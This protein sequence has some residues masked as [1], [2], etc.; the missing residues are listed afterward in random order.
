M[1]EEDAI[2]TIRDVH[3]QVTLQEAIA[4][5]QKADG[6]VN[7]AC[8]FIFAA[9]PAPP[10]EVIT[11]SSDDETDEPAP[12]WWK[13]LNVQRWPMPALTDLPVALQHDFLPPQLAQDLFHFLLEQSKRWRRTTF[14]IG[15]RDVRSKHEAF[16]YIADPDCPANATEYDG[17][18]GEN[19]SS[20]EIPPLLQDA[21]QR[22]EEAIHRHRQARKAKYHP[23][24]LPLSSTWKVGL[25]IVNKY[26]HGDASLG[27]H[28][29]KVNDTLLTPWQTFHSRDLR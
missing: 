12:T 26:D 14:R 2:R 8:E 7:R 19:A 27:F 15:G 16:A 1:Q 24:E 21:I 28:S 23:L 17:G 18:E 29:D 4:W 22:V 10:P 3:P 9:P 25:V 5:L 11:L 13:T 6:N 20:R